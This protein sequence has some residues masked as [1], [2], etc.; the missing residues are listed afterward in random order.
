MTTLPRSI[1]VIFKSLLLFIVGVTVSNVNAQCP[2]PNPTANAVSINCGQTATLNASGGV[3]YQWFSNAAG[4]QLVGSGASFVTPA[5]TANATYYVASSVGLANGTAFNFTN[6]AATGH[7]GPTQAQVNAAYSGTNLAGNVSVTGS[8]FQNWTV[9]ATGTYRIV[10]RGA[11]G[12]GSGGQGAIMQGD[13]TLNAG[14]VIRILVGQNGT[15]V[16]PAGGGGGSFVVRSPYNTTGN[17]LIVAGGGSGNGNYSFNPGLTSTNGG[18]GGGAGG[19]NGAGGSGGTRS[20]GGGGFLGNGANCSN[21]SYAGPGTS[22]VNGGLG[23]VNSWNCGWAGA[24]GG[25][26]GGAS[27]GGNC[28]PNGGAGGGFSGGGGSSNGLAGGG[29]SVNNG[30]NQVNQQGAH[31]GQGQ[32]TITFMG[33][34][35]I[36]ALVPVNVT[37]ALPSAPTANGAVV[38]CGATAALSALGGTGTYA[39]FSN[40]TGTTQVGTGANFTTPQLIANTTYYVGSTSAGG[41]G[42]AGTVYTFTNCSATG[43]FG[44]TQ[45]QVNSAYSSTNLN[46]LV[47]SQSGVQLWTVPSSGTYRIEGFG[48]QGGGN[49]QFGRGAQIRGDFALTAGQQLKIIVGQAGGVSSSGSGGGGSFVATSANVPLLV[50]GGGGGQYDGSSSL[51][52]AHAVTVNGGQPTGCT[53]GGAG[54]NGGNGCNSSGAAGGGGFSGN[55][56]SGTYGTG[57]A[58][59]TNGGNGGNHGSNAICVGGFGGG[60][61]THGNTGGG[62]GGGGYSG[63]AGGYHSGADGSGGGGG[64]YNNGTSQANVGGVRIGQG[65]VTITSMSSSCVSAVVPVAITVN[66]PTTPTANNASI[67]CG[68]T[69]TLTASNGT[70][71]YVWY[72]DPAGTQQVATGASFTTPALISSTTYYVATTSGQAGCN[73]NSLANILNGVNTNGAAIGSSVP[74]GY[75]FTMDGPSGANSN[76][77]SDGGNDMYDGG[78]YISTN[79][80]NNINYSDG[81]IANSAAFGAGGQY[82]TK[83][84]TNMWVLAADVVNLSSF[85]ISGNNGADGSGTYNGTT[86]SVTVGCQTYKVMLKRVYSAGDPSIN[87][88]V[89]IPNNAGATHTW[90]TNTDNTQHDISGL[91]G[92]TRLYY[93]LYAANSGG[94]IDDNTATSIATTFLTQISATTAAQALCQSNLAPVTVTVN[95][96]V[97]QP[98]ISGTTTINCGATSTLTSSSGNNTAWYS[99]AA[100]GNLLGTGSPFTTTSLAAGTTIYAVQAN[101]NQGSQ[102]FNYTGSQQT[103]TVP[104]GVTSVNVDVQGAQGG[105][106]GYGTAGLGGRTQATIPVSPGATI[107]VNVGGQGNYS[108]GGWNG[109]G[110]PYGCGCVGGG[111]G[112]SDIRI[113]GNTLANRT[114]V[115]G[116]GG[117]AGYYWNWTNDHGG[118]GGGLSGEAGKTNNAYNVSYCGQGGTQVAGGAGANQGGPA[119]SLGNGGGSGY[120]AGS[121]GGGYYG[122]G[123]GYGGGGGGGGS[124]F[125][126]NQATGVTQTQGFKSGNGLV[127][128]SW[129]SVGCAST[130]V[131]VPITVNA[132]AAPTANAAVVGCGTTANLIAS[133]G[134]GNSYTWYTNS[135]GTGAVASGANYTT[136]ALTLGTTYYV[137]SVSTTP[138]SQSFNYTGAQQTWTVPAGVTSITVDAQGSQGG[139]SS[140]G[141]GGNGGRVQATIS[142]TPGQTVYV[143][144]GG[145]G[146]MSVGGWNGGGV[147][148]GCGCVAGGGGATDIRIGGVA[149]ADRKIVA[150]GGG[151]AGYYWNWTNDHGGVGGGLVGGGGYTNNSLN[152][153]YCGQGGT[154]AAGG[155]GA[156]QG[157]PAGSLGNGGGSGYYAG[158]GGG[159]YYGGGSGYGG[160]GGGGGSS[161]T[162]PTASAITH[163]QGFK[164]GNGLVTI[165]W[166]TAVCAS[167]LTPVAITVNALTTPTANNVTINCGQTT[168]ITAS[169]NLG[170]IN[171]YSNANGSTLLVA[172]AS[173]TTPQL[174]GTTTYYVGAGAG[175]CATAIIPVVVTVNALASPSVANPNVNINCGQTT[176]LS[177]VGGGGNTITWYSNAAGSTIAGTG[178]PWTTPA[179]TSAT[180]YYVASTTGMGA[181]TIYT[182]TNCSATGQF[183]PTQAQ[184][185]SAYT[186]TNLASLVTSSSG[187]QLWTVPTTATYRIEAFGAQGGG[188]NQFGQGAQIRGD[189]QLTAGQQIKILVGQQ[190]G[191]STSGSGGGGSFVTTSANVPLLVAGG[192]GGQ[193]STSSLLHNAHAVTANNGQATGCTSGGVGGNGGNGCNN[194]GASGGGGL[195]SNG[196]SGSYGTGGLSFINGGNGGNHGSNATCVG[197]FGGGGGTHG[198][199]GGGGGGGGYSGGA[200]GYHDNN[201]GSGGGGGSF[202]SGTNPLVAGGVRIG[203]GLVTITQMSTPCSSNLIP[204]AVSVNLPASPSAAV[205]AVVSC[206]QTAVL[207]ANGGGGNTYY[208][209]SNA[210]GSTQVGT[211][212]SFTTPALS[213]SA[214]YYVSSGTSQAGSQTFNYTGSVQTFT[215]PAAGVYTIEA[216]GAQGGNDPSNPNAIFGGR[217]GYAKGD[218]TLTAG[219]TIQVYVGQQGSG[220]M[221]SNWRST[222]GGGAT[223]FRLTGGNWNDNAGLLSRILVA[224]GG[225]GRH[226]NN[227]EGVAYVGN[228]GGGSTAPNF[229]A[230]G[231]SVTGSTQNGGGSSNN[232]NVVGSFGFSNPTPY[233]N[234]CSVGGWNGGARGSDNWANGGGGGGWWGGVSSW[235]TGSGGSGYAYT[236]ASWTPAGYTPTAAVQLANTQLIAGNTVMPNPAG[237]TMTGR[238]GNGIAKITWSGSGCQSQLIPVAVSV[239]GPAAPVAANAVVNCGAPTTLNASNGGGQIYTWYSDA[240]GTQQIST[241]AAYTTPSLSTTTTYYVNSGTSLAAATTYTFSNAAASGSF[242]PTQAQLNSTYNG[243]S[244]AGTVTSSNGIQLWTVPATGVYTIDARGARGGTYPGR[245]SGGNG[246]RMVGTFNLTAGQQIKILVGQEGYYGGGGG[247]S[248][249]AT[250]ANTPLIVAGG[251]GGGG[252]ACGGPIPHAGITA[253]G[254]VNNAPCTGSIYQGGING[255][256]GNGPGTN[257]GPGGGFN[258][259]GTPADGN[260][261]TAFVNG[262]NGGASGTY[263]G[264][265]GGGGGSTDDQGAGGGGYSGGAGDVEDGDGG[266]G[267][268]FNAGTNQSNTAAYQAGNG[269]VIIT[270]MTTPCVSNLTPVTVTVN[271]IAAPVVAGN[272]AICA[273]GVANTTLTA[274]G[275]P[276]GYAWYANANGTG[277]LGTN[278]AY[279]TPNINATT[280]YYVQSAT[281]QAGSQTFNYTGAIQSFTAPVAGTYT[282]EVWGAQGGG[283]T[284]CYGTGGAGGYS[285]GNVTLTAGQVIYVGVGQAGFKSSSATAYNGGGAGNVYSP[286]HGYT[287]G[288]ATHIATA[289]GVLA[290]LSGNQNSVLVVAGGGG[291]ATGGTCVCQYQANG[292]AG[293]GTTGVSGTCSGNDCGYRPAGSGGTQNAGGT[294]QS[295]QIAAAFG[296]GAT[297]STNTGDCIQGGG[298]GGG[299]YGGGAGGHAGGGGGGGSGYVAPALTVTQVTA[300]NA[301]MPN[302]AGGNMTGR[303]GDGIAKITWSGTGCVSSLTPVTVTVNALPAAPSANAASICTGQTA[304][305]NASANSNW[306]TVPNGGASIGQAQAYTTPSLNN[307]VTYYM[308]GVNGPCVSAT[309]TAVTVT[310]NPGPASNAGLSIVDA[311]TCGKNSVNV[312]GNALAA[313]QVGQ[314]TWTNNA[315]LQ[316]VF[317]NAGQSANDV[318]TGQYG[319]TY[320]LQWQITNPSN[321]CIGTDT[322]VVTFN[323]PIDASITG[324]IGTGDLLWCGLTGT[325]WSTSTNWYQKQ[326]AGHYIR[327]FGAV[328]PAINNEVFTVSIPNAGFCVGTN[329]PTLTVASNSED[330]YVGPGITWNLSN[331]S[332]NIAQ[333][334]VNNGTIIASTGVVNFT[335]SSNSTVSGSGNT[336][337]FD[338]RVN[339]SA[340][341]TLTLQQP[342]LVT[343]VLS[344][345]QGNVFTTSANLLTLG[346]SSAAPGSLTYNSGTIVGPFKR[347]F[348]NAASAGTAGLF[349]VGTAVYNRYADFSFGSG[350]GVDQY[351]TVEYLTGA[352]LQGGIPLYNGLPLIASGSLIQNY[353]ADGYW[354][355]IPTNNNYAEPITSVNYGVTLFANNLTGMQS[356][357]V[358]RIIKSAGS[359]TTGQHHVAWQACGTHTPINGAANPQA[360]LITSTAT[361]GF[362]WFN[363]GTPNSQALPV[364]LL[365]FNGDCNEGQV[366]LSWQTATEHNSDY[367]E[368]EKSRDGMNWQVLTTVN[369]A[370]N[371]TQLLNYEATDAHAMEGNNYYRLTQVDIDGTTK[372]YDVINVSC[373]GAAKGYFSAYPNPS[374]GSFQVILNDKNLIG[375]GNLSVKDTKGAELLNR[376]IEVKP[377]INMFSVTDLNLAPGVYYIQIVNG[378]RATE[379]LKEVIR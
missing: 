21:S 316:G 168:T 362:S 200:G 312:G 2:P 309:R 55:G 346:T 127:T 154:Q 172:G 32:V 107:I 13:F 212:A 277:A 34:G 278:A 51:Y 170:A 368:V 371:S 379:V 83:K 291:G 325:D 221:N 315:G 86:L 235:P 366:N 310:V 273:N 238:S 233:S 243:T 299:W 60:G 104:A 163:T 131:S 352:P 82:F 255:A 105:N 281:P 210:N 262:G 334:L 268:S 8:G 191:V 49:N 164:T 36:S 360:F 63:G 71:T 372:T 169:N 151:G 356:P 17:V 227:Y 69:A 90:A 162:D 211:G 130:P 285:K 165:S 109:G 20:A 320:T 27:A 301:S 245:N 275:S 192:G 174:S 188:A 248:F 345:N 333:N 15:G 201:T 189:F 342:V 253:N 48:A 122:G 57:G 186:A 308:E 24:N 101:M 31:A 129:N 300:G 252:S 304:T 132:L 254:G 12:G 89:I 94:Y 143:N 187:I 126:N 204:V 128:I 305:L 351:L 18:F 137:A 283:G 378:E 199:T 97:A 175:A 374:T 303:L 307:T 266:A 180:T 46:G 67:N 240:Q 237:S 155:A 182:F 226:G 23:G 65:L 78:N 326:A 222:G 110:T 159:G 261:G 85:S 103:W 250:S 167:A 4:S 336:Q 295:A 213:G 25:F 47:T 375:S 80:G 74:N 270:F 198:S 150:G 311:S 118:N 323:Q 149:L 45:A 207:N 271:A 161:F 263:Y 177:A 249:V 125:A 353:S 145:Q 52:N 330:V 152:P 247:G 156:S 123:S 302:P 75:N 344:M 259:N 339:K 318:F 100:G 184:V 190:G 194:S 112:A 157:G 40:S 328:Q 43:Q 121:G 153:T 242:G 274:S 3:N 30:T 369:A 343:N 272:T 135:N 208:W 370:G 219:Q 329:N 61:G 44:P 282:V 206:G 324:L 29:G 178:S 70:G 317:S 158:S 108:T 373:S 185:N 77:I 358:C 349:P 1:S 257:G 117:G 322:M 224:G 236:A 228:D 147:P 377:G 256:G 331:D 348:A 335:G 116:G 138:G 59:F 58:S 42:A 79:L 216:W 95:S 33:Q 241:G 99:A 106:T 38:N 111:G 39:W 140:Y 314:W 26:G 293:G 88:M 287:G 139:T 72:S 280:T 62:G 76:Y 16:S 279:T 28:I 195:S 144:V 133:N 260:H 354:S 41:G 265:F 306:Y 321:G 193:Y 113:G 205:P 160:G 22:F 288:G 264:G 183:G 64:S 202:N 225:G 119:G 102:V 115:A 229:T 136:P 361:Q 93:L 286:D 73:A 363:I 364:E 294:S 223:D 66:P 217:G 340:G 296:L 215:A 142:V 269:Q 276:S 341:A 6:A 114:I 319:A 7:V 56:G 297:A 53:T 239:N 347:F 96:N 81:V 220:C 19:S 355:V 327:M 365:S 181:G 244:L 284:N 148:Y 166:N 98:V 9:P 209:Y 246:A 10:T 337:L 87:Q 367:F 290:S 146:S 5:L 230:N 11:L 258:T 68:N 338:M 292:G 50:A 267:G 134:A 92:T 214:T 171:W 197:G 141:T 332:I 231:T 298:G 35:C 218:V 124:S 313:G 289:T 203:H 37:V 357:Q 179:L 84:L 91:A 14:E 376:T 173:Y 54:G 359:N 350:P 234:S 196:G 251:G 176:A 232:T 120:Y